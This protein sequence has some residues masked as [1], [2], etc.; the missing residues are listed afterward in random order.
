MIEAGI[1]VAILAGAVL[2]FAGAVLVGLALGRRLD[3][4]LVARAA[5]DDAAAIHDAED[6]ESKEVPDEQ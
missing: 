2:L 6:A 5:R 3:R 1:A 4:A